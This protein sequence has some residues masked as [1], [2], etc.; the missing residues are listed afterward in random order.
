MGGQI[1][2]YGMGSGGVNLVKD[3]LE[4]DDVEATQ[5][6]NAE[7]VPDESKGGEG[8]LSKRGGLSA[9]TSALAGSILG[10]VAL[11]LQSN[12]V[13]TLYIAMGSANAAKK[14]LKTTDGT[15]FTTA[16]TPTLGA[17]QYDKYTA[18]LAGQSALTSSPHGHGVT[19]KNRALYIGDDYTPGDTTLTV[20]IITFDGTNYDT[21]FRIPM[22]SNTDGTG[23]YAVTDVLQANGKIYIAVA[24]KAAS[25]SFH[26]GRVLAYDPINN[27]LSQVC[28]AIGSGTGEVSGSNVPVCLAWFNGQLFCGLHASNSG[29]ADIGKVIRCY[30]SVD[31]TW[32]T[33][34]SNLNGK[35]NAMI[36]FKGALYVCTD[37][38][39]S[40]ATVSKR[41]TTGTWSDVETVSGT[42]SY[43]QPQVYNDKLYVCQVVDDVSDTVKIRVTTDGASWS[44]SRDVYTNDL[45]SN[46]IKP[47][48][49]IVFNGLLFYAFPPNTGSDTGTDGFLLKFNGTTWTKLTSETNIGGQMFT[50]VTRS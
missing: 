37:T 10:M 29:T 7:L 15:T 22:G 49:S 2:V 41:G 44:D 4:L 21:L 35:P 14:W 30:P 26:G 8:S 34:V 40:I 16:S 33:D 31:T 27:T 24:E 1:S 17:K 48:G 38:S 32:T 25:S 46:R 43:M 45:G 12:Y 3:P 18:V 50:L 9:L 6:Q 13:R 11:P 42:S 36:V 19:Y 47:T 28:N 20:P 5:L 39:D 23:P